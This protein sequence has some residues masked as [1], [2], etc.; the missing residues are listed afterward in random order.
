MTKQ[1][2]KD[3][4]AGVSREGSESVSERA[5]A[6]PPTEIL[7]FLSLLTFRITDYTRVASHLRSAVRGSLAAFCGGTVVCSFHGARHPAA[8]TSTLCTAYDCPVYRRG[9]ASGVV[10]CLLFVRSLRVCGQYDVQSTVSC[11]RAPCVPS[12]APSMKFL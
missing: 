11:V 10:T 6:A 12:H 2:A 9:V 1:W 8:A 4:T 3:T 5:W 7:L